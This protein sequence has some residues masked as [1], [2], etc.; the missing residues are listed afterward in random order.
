MLFCF[1]REA[2]PVGT[3][4]HVELDH[5][6]FPNRW[7]ALESRAGLFP[8]EDSAGA[9]GSGAGPAPLRGPRRRAGLTFPCVLTFVCL[10]TATCPTACALGSCKGRIGAGKRV[11]RFRVVLLLVAPQAGVLATA[12]A[13]EKGSSRSPRWAAGPPHGRGGAWRPPAAARPPTPEP[14]SGAG[15]ALAGRAAQPPALPRVPGPLAVPG[16]QRDGSPGIRSPRR[17]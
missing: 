1:L 12:S 15:A 7:G 8:A 16:S 6:R 3:F 4:K 2:L 13:R 14:R 10:R 9:A 5:T 17:A 11:P